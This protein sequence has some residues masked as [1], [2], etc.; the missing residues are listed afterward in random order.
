MRKCIFTVILLLFLL[1]GLTGGVHLLYA[2]QKRIYNDGVI[3]YVPLSASFVLSAD[4]QESTLDVIQYSVDG[5]P[6]TIY[7][8][9]I[10]F[11]TEG[12]HFIAWRAIDKTGNISE[13][14]I[15]PVIVDGT[16][17]E[18]IASVDGA[19]FISGDNIYITTNSAVVLWAEDDLSGVDN[20]YVKLDDGKF[21]PYRKP[22]VVTKEGLHTA[23]AY[24]VD[25]VGNSTPVYIVQGYVDSTAPNVRIMTKK[26]FITVGREKY[27]SRDNEYTVSASDA[28]AG[29]GEILVSL[30][31][32]EFVN[33]SG[34]FKIQIPGKHTLGAKAVDNLGNVS[35]VASVKF[36][37]DVVPPETSLGT[38]LD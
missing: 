24:S 6:V 35:A 19:S 30:D 28:I 11:D 1:S 20:I 16:P 2:Q 8:D 3:D 22:L 21:F 32:S 29:V 34:P 5:N 23:E 36:F 15:K 27:T 38:T 37:V 33:Y 12:R 17:P 7:S 25:N 18:G 14:R 26:K 13:E 9:P 31:G 4:D 10:S